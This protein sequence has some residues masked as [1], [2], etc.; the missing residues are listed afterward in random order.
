VLTIDPIHIPLF[1]LPAV[2]RAA[3]STAIR[4]EHSIMPPYL[5]ALYSLDPAKNDEIADIIRSIVRQ[6][7][8]HMVLAC[9]V[10]NAIGGSPRIDDPA[11]VHRYPDP[12]PGTGAGSPPVPLA[13]FSRGL[14]QEVFLPIEAPEAPLPYP[15][16]HL[17][18]H[19]GG[20]TVGEFYRAIWKLLGEAPS[21]IFSGKPEFQ[22]REGFQDIVCVQ[23]LASARAA[24][25]VIIEQGEGNN[26]EP[27]DAKGELAHFFKFDSILHE[28]TLIKA[29]VGAPHPYVFEGKPIPFDPA[30]VCKVPTMPRAAD[31][32]R[33]TAARRVIDEFNYTYTALLQS[34]HGLANG[35]PENFPDAYGLMFSLQEQAVGMMRGETPAGV[36]VGPTFEYLAELP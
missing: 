12:L 23:D 29:P 15:C 24:I 30:G 16:P 10:L 5:Y 26:G 14:V 8:L 33:G 9:N 21:T 27:M 36:P 32:A 20:P 3:L 6:E 25:D 11:F 35:H 17:G 1:P 22:I 28:A 4:F 19:P 7:M 2:L 18:I 34:L 31:Y 13:P